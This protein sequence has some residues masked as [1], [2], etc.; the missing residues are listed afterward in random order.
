MDP[1]MMDPAVLA[2]MMGGAPPAPDMG[3]GLPPMPG[4]MDP[5]MQ[6]PAMAMGMAPPGGMPS[7]GPGAPQFPS[8]DPSVLSQILGL[9]GELRSTDQ[10]ALQSQ[11]DSVLM[12]LLS[13]LGV[14]GLAP[15]AGFVEGGGMP[16]MPPEQMAY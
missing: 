9:L 14:G 13:Q 4:P 11:Q 16:M 7:L 1:S 2:Q 6:D 3:M 12:E 15:D 10:M 8:T 5:M